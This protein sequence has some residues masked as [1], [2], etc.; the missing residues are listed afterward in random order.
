MWL[1]TIKNGLVRWRNGEAEQI[2]EE[3]GLVQ[4]RALAQDAA[5]RVWVGTE[6]GLVFQRE[7]DRFV[8]V[9]LPGSKPRE[10]IRFI[11]PDEGNLWIGAVNGGLYRWRSGQVARLPH[12]AGLPVDDLRVLEIAPDGDFWI[13]T[14]QGMFCVARKEIEAAIDGRKQSMRLTGYRRSDGMPSVDFMFGFKNTATRTHDGHLWFATSRGAL[15]ILPQDVQ[16]TV[17]PLPVLIEEVQVGSVSMPAGAELSLPPNPGTVQIRYTLPELSSP[18]QVV[19]RYRVVGWGDNW[20]LADHERIAIFTHLPPGNYRFEVEAAEAGGPWLPAISSLDISVRAAWWEMGLFRVSAA[21]AGM[22][23]F[24][25]LVRAIMK[26]RFH[27]RMQRLEQER[28]LERERARI[29]RDMHD[30]LG[31]SL[32]RITLMSELAAREAGLPSVASGQ[33]G[34]IA[35]AARAVSGT[36]DQIVWTVNPRNDTLERLIGYVG[37]VA[38]EYLDM[39]GIDLHMELPAEIPSRMV[40]SDARHQVLLV[41]KEALN[42]IAKYAHAH[43]VTMQIAFQ[44]GGIGIVITDDGSGFD[45]EGV[46]SSANGLRNMRERMAALGGGAKITSKPGSGTAVTFWAPL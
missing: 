5:G 8:P 30:D 7:N 40:S 3:E 24:G 34:A 6:D 39:A 43:R 46:V 29:A 4:P 45:P 23:A 41:V 10:Q 9:P 21:I 14:G 38:S 26:R 42:N 35:N 36:L 44:R 1:A 25:W 13:G 16:S 12:D 11:V 19:F 20:I 2:P 32:T 15:E 37:E 33:F 17:A 31:A 22:L 28:A 18:E 27:A